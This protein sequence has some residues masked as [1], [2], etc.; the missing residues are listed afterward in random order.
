VDGGEPGRLSARRVHRAQPFFADCPA[1]E[2]YAEAGVNPLT[3]QFIEA[4]GTGTSVGDPIECLALG[5]VLD[6]KGRPASTA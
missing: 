2:V 5:A 1:A 3:V 4:H 6:G